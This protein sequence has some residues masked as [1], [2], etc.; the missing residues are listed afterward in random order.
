MWHLL[1]L[2]PL[3]DVL[4]PS[5]ELLFLSGCCSLCEETLQTQQ[6][7]M[8]IKPDRCQKAAS[9]Q[10]KTQKANW[11]T[12]NQHQISHSWSLQSQTN[13]PSPTFGQ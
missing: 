1:P 3:T 12:T 13:N 6:N 8:K 9:S 5:E 2:P 7:P 11:Q 4:V 10:T